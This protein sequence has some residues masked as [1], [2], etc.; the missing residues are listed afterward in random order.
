MNGIGASSLRRFQP[1]PWLGWTLAVLLFLIL[2]V[3]PL[4]NRVT[5]DESTLVY[6]AHRVSAGQVPYRDFFGLWAPGGYYVFSGGPW[7][8]W[9]RPETGCRYLQV[10][11]LLLFT[12]VLARSLRRWGRW[13]WPLA[14]LVPVVLFPMAAFMGNHWFAVMAYTAAVLLAAH[15]R[16][17]PGSALEWAALG[18]LAVLAGWFLQT[19]GFL[20][21]VLLLLTLL[22]VP[23]PAGTLAG[24]VL[25][26]TGGGLAAVIIL[27]APVLTAGAGM[28][29]LRDAVL[30]PLANYRKPGNVADVPFMDGLP[31]RLAALFMR[32]EGVSHVAWILEAV[33][34]MVLYVALILGFAGVCAAALN[35]LG[36]ALAR[37]EGLTP[38]KTTASVLTLLALLLFWRVN[39][40]WVHFVYALVPVL[41]LWCLVPMEPWHV[42]WRKVYGPV[43]CV[44]LACGVLYNAR[45]FLERPHASWEYKDVDRVDRDSPLN[46]SLRAL[47]FMRPGDTIAVLPFGASTYLYTYQ[48]AVGYTQLFVLELN[49]HT[50]EDHHRVAQEI[51]RRRPK[52]VLFHRI[53]EASFMAHSD[54]I[55]SVI[56]EGYVRWTETPAVVVYLR[57][58]VV[59]PP[60]KAGTL[61]RGAR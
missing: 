59:V 55:S 53:S 19:Q 21:L 44:L 3:S 9:G 13:A 2:Q 42:R 8:W 56:R 39:P 58:D 60:A 54:P 46:R 27:L 38:A 36:Q 23:T 15:V 52:M 18:A 12:M 10:A 16:E 28:D 20:A 30:W 25:R 5:E 14:A 1:L 35:H 6:D 32:P 40:A 26:A 7:G 61:N 49:H 33:A 24:R 17:S 34:G 51:L 57:K 48:A 50:L 22:L 41:V 29:L 43:I 31:D 45:S 11:I 4:V 47:P 37:R